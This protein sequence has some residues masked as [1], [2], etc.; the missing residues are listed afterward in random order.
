MNQTALISLQCILFSNNVGAKTPETKPT[1]RATS[2]L[3][4]PADNPQ[5]FLKLP[6]PERRSV[7]V[8]PAVVRLSAAGE[9]GS[10]VI[11]TQPQA[12]FS[13]FCKNTPTFYKTQQ[14]QH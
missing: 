14:Y 4:Q 10:K 6:T 1:D 9:G 5:S 7:P 8:R 11:P 3:A 13:T 2:L 12:L